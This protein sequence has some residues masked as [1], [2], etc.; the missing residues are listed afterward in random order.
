MSLSLIMKMKICFA[1]I[2][3]FCTV[4]A[5]N[6][7][8]RFRSN[9]S[10]LISLPLKSQSGI[11]KLTMIQ[12]CYHL[13]DQ[14]QCP[15]QVSGIPI[16]LQ[17]SFL[18]DRMSCILRRPFGW[19][20]FKIISVESHHLQDQFILRTIFTYLNLNL[21]TKNHRKLRYQEIDSVPMAFA[22]RESAVLMAVLHIS[23]SIDCLKKTASM[24]QIVV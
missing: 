21:W 12:S 17:F 23:S 11:S 8:D 3:I 15:D 5:G 10:I 7:R 24:S 16:G 2:G 9:G 19:Q 1:I 20:V 14:I 6:Y 13:A 22:R 18:T 4:A